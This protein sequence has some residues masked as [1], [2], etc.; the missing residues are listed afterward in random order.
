MP[1]F[2]NTGCIQL[3]MVFSTRC[4][5]YGP[6]EPVCSLVHCKFVYKLT[7]SAQDYTPAP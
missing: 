7:H 2:R 5:G 4:C 3:H 6:K 1:I